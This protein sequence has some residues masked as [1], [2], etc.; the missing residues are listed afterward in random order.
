[1]RH[2]VPRNRRVLIATH[3]ISETRKIIIDFANWLSLFPYY[4]RDTFLAR[5][6]HFEPQEKHT[7]VTTGVQAKH[8][9]FF[10]GPVQKVR[11]FAFYGL[12][13]SNSAS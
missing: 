10:P 11:V 6:L 13:F 3:G 2:Q 9:K 7:Y 1:M 12:R 4:C 5:V 8:V